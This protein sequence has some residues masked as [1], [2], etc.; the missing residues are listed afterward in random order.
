MQRENRRLAAIVA[1]DIA[2]HSRLIGQDEEGTLRATTSS[3]EVKKANSA[4]EII[5]GSM[6][7]RSPVRPVAGVMSG[8]RRPSC[9]PTWGRT[10]LFPSI[11]LFGLAGA[12]AVQSLPQLDVK[13]VLAIDCSYSVDAREFELQKTGLAEAF[14]HPA[15][16][17]AIQAGARKAIGVTVVQW[18]AQGTQSVAVP[19]TTVEDAPSAARRAARLAGPERMAQKGATSVSAMIQVG[20]RVLDANPLQGLRRV[21]DISSDGRN[22]TGHSI[23]AAQALALIEGVTVN[24]LAILNE[25]PTLHLYFEQQLISGPHAFVIE[26]ADYDDYAIAILGKLIREIGNPATS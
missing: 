15:V 21:I 14:R 11:L 5:P 12:P 3:N 9:R 16:L 26:A 18:S 4:P 24:G 6:P 1:A 7:W 8:R 10:F 13:L 19:W 2:G 22:N 20:V 23:A 25:V 17:A